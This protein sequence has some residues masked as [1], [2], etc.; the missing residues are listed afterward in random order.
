MFDKYRIKRNST[1]LNVPPEKLFEDWAFTIE[2]HQWGIFG[3]FFGSWL[4]VEKNTPLR[5]L[6]AKELV[7]QGM[8]IK[9][10]K[11]QATKEISY[12]IYGWGIKKEIDQYDSFYEG[13]IFY[14]KNSK[15]MLQIVEEKQDEY[16]IV[17]FNTDLKKYT[18][19][20]SSNSKN[21]AMTLK[22]ADYSFMSKDSPL[23]MQETP[24]KYV[25]NNHLNDLSIHPQQA[26]LI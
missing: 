10:A 6:R 18:G 7:S 21:L 3:V 16:F 23:R 25:I 20:F 26:S 8:S 15:T 4:D 12:K 5:Q 2:K 11:K 17:E 13:Y 9:E 24:L 14:L 19:F 22:T 1:R